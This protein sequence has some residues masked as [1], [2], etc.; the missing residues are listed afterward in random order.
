[1]LAG[2]TNGQQAPLDQNQCLGL[3]PLPTVMIDQAAGGAEVLECGFNSLR[4]WHC[5]LFQP[6]QGEKHRRPFTFLIM[7]GGGWATHDVI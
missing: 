5:D 2:F 7:R 3:A 4:L 6:S 1:M